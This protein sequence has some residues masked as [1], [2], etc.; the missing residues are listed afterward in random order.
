LTTI[1]VDLTDVALFLRRGGTLTG[2][3]RV[4]I[5]ALWEIMRL[6]R[7]LP[8][9]GLIVERRGACHA[10]P[11]DFLARQ[12]TFDADEFS[13]HACQDMSDRVPDEIRL[14]KRLAAYPGPSTGARLRRLRLLLGVKLGAIV[15]PGR[16]VAQGLLRPGADHPSQQGVQRDLQLTAQDVYVSLG[17]AW[18]RD[19]SADIA[20]RHAARGGK[21]V[22]MVHDLV[23]VLRTDLHEGTVNS[24]FGR[25]LDQMRLCTSLFL[26]VSQNTAN[27]LAAYLQERGQSKPIRVTRLAHEFKGHAR[28]SQPPMPAG[29]QPAVRALAG[30]SFVL[31]VG[32]VEGRKNGA[33]LIDAWGQ[34]L[35]D[36]GRRDVTLVFSGRPGWLAEAFSAA[37]GRARQ[38]GLKIEVIEG[39]TDE[40]LAWLYSH[41]LFSAYPS[42]YEGWGLPV[43]ESLW[44]GTYCLASNATSIPEVGGDLIR[45]F[46]PQDIP[47]MTEAL[48]WALTQP[49]A[50]ATA[51]ATLRHAPLRT[52][53]DHGQDL[54]TACEAHATAPRVAA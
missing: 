48:R 28:N 53:R 11:L 39:C 8:L 51:V 47:A 32:S 40:D 21:V 3:Q 27:D 4:E 42:L 41:A 9:K 45:Y 24:A 34:A 44:F 31:C 14:R 18:N 36:S 22:Q 25:W 43:G 10:F 35:Q 33:R 29:T 23:P 15:Q 46:S 37:L 12:Q 5:N 38:Q 30:T 7:T 2:I 49:D 20:Q 17:T 1:Y 50:L 19:W 13:L 26:C 16:L 6:P 52:W 54:L